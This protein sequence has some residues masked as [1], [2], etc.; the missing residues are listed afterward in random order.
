MEVQ[1]RLLL[2]SIAK[3]QILVKN[4]M[5]YKV[6]IENLV[7]KPCKNRCSQSNDREQQAK[8]QVSRI[9][10]NDQ[11]VMWEGTTYV[12]ELGGSILHSFE[13]AEDM[14]KTKDAIL[15]QQELNCT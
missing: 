1:L 5:D 6:I 3:I 14:G 9:Q 12:M 11:P 4:Q 7:D 15:F 8:R 10:T 13:I 2:A